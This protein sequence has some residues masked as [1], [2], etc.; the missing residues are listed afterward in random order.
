MEN[1]TVFILLA[2]GKSERMGITKGI[3]E[4]K[5]TYW[6]LEQLNRI[7]KAQIA[8]VRIGLGFNYQHYFK[9][10][11][12]LAEAQT[13]FVYFKEM[14]VRVVINPNPE[15]GSFSTLQT[16]LEKIDANPVVL[17][18]P[19]DIPIPNATVLKEIIKIENKIVLPNFEGKNGHPIKLS[20]SFWKPLPQLDPKEENA[21]LDFQI[22]KT[23]SNEITQVVVNDASILK[24]LNTPIDWADFLKNS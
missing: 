3:L 18:S 13:T 4:Y 11:P 15:W 20:A 21:R 23:K 5:N 14:K 1:N 22:K 9:A 6:I 7:S 19:I 2:G 12:W 24:N 16:V 10:I 17:I 8:E